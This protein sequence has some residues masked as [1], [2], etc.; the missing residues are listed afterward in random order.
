MLCQRREGGTC[1][2]PA[3]QRA[4]QACL[5]FI[6]GSAIT[7]RRRL[8]VLKASQALVFLAGFASGAF[9]ALYRPDSNYG[10]SQIN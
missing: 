8:P 4:I 6:H 5:H 2:R 9:A 3:K 7:G 10:N 1:A